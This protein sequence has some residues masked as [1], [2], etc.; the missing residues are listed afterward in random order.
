MTD[1]ISVQDKL[2]KEN[3]TYL[4]AH[5]S[6]WGGKPHVYI[7]TAN[8]LTNLRDNPQFEYE[9]RPNKPGFYNG[10]GEYDWVERNVTHWMPLPEPPKEDV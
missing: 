5:K 8:F 6:C 7:E 9:G 2:P 3:G 10:D 4:V 1:W